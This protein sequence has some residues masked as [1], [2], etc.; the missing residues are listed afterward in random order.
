MN[1]IFFRKTDESIN[2]Q[3]FSNFDNDSFFLNTL[4]IFKTIA[5]INIHR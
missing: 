3:T 2:I 1:T 5:S 4:I